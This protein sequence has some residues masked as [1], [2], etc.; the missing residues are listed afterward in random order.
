MHY[1]LKGAARKD[2]LLFLMEMIPINNTEGYTLVSREERP[3]HLKQLKVIL[4]WKS[5]LLNLKNMSQLHFSVP[6]VTLS[7]LV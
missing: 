5:E 4:P 1:D 7:W 6:S 2:G 3:T